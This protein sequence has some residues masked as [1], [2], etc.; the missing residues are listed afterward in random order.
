MF[1]IMRKGGFDKIG[2]YRRMC[3]VIGGFVSEKNNIKVRYAIYF[4][5]F[6][7]CLVIEVSI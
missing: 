7:L 4:I 5:F 6:N 2:N 3:V 1:N